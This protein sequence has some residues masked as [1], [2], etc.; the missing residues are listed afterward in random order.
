L[1]E[2]FCQTIFL[3]SFSRGGGSHPS[4][5]FPAN[6]IGPYLTSDVNISF[7]FLY[8]SPPNSGLVRFFEAAFFDENA[9]DNPDVH[10]SLGEIHGTSDP[11]FRS[12]YIHPIFLPSPEA[13]F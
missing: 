3:R 9:A 10:R 1:A 8:V 13:P 7:L 6:G 4:I 5:S 11:F 12:P 2:R